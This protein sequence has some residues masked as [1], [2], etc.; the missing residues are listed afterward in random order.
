MGASVEF[1]AE[2]LPLPPGELDDDLARLDRLV[3][4]TGART[5]RVLGDLVQG[6]V[7]AATEAR[8]AEWRASLP[9]ALELV[10]G[11]HDRHQATLPAAWGVTMLPA[12]VHEGPFAFSHAP[13]AVPSAFVWAGHVH[14]TA[15]LSGRADRLRFPAFV[16]VPGLGLL[17]AFSRFTGGATIRASPGLQRFLCVEGEVVALELTE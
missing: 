10:P 8:V 6:A 13:T 2:G 9:A 17:P 11:N 3:A 16:V 5:V 12:L 14:P 7:K 1:R 4:A 15:T